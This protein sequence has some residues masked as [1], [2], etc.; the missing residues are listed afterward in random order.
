MKRKT[1]HP[2]YRT[3]YNMIMRCEYPRCDRYPHYGG[4]GI[5]VCD[6]WRDSLEAFAEDMGP[7]PSP[8][9][10][11]DR[12]DVNG[13]YEP[14]NCRWATRNEQA[15][16]N[17]RARLVEIQG[18]TYHVAELEEKYGVSART[19]YYRAKHGWPLERV[20]SPKK[21]YNNTESQKKAAAAHAAKQKAK[22]HC[23]RGHPLSGDNLYLPPSGLRTCRACKRAYDK[24]LYYKKQRPLESFL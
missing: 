11:L 18:Q 10:S 2:L 15:R 13:N 1:Q 22:T 3:W 21:Q 6:R 5:R 24:Y 4:R 19:I 12:I 16:N 23:K 20:V 14:E 8:T 9:H 7:K 17:Q